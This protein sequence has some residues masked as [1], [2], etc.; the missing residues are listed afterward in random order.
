MASTTTQDAG[1]KYVLPT[2]ASDAARL[3]VIHDVYGPISIR[4][5]EAAAVGEARSAADIGCGTGT[6]SR[7]LAERMGKGSIVDAIDISEDQ[8]AV[9]RNVKSA[10]GASTINYSVASAY[11][12][13]LAEGQ[14]DLVFVRLVLCHLKEPKKAVVAMAKLLKPGGRLVAVDMDRYSTRAMPPSEHYERWL[15]ASHHSKI[16]VD[17]SVGYRLHD[18]MSDAGLRTTFLAADQPIYNTGPGKRLW[19]N[20]W[21]NALP[22]FVR[23]GAVTQEDGE[24]MI[25]G[26]A[27]HN[28]RPDVWIAVAKMFAAVG[29][30]AE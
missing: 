18:L 12:P 28:A 14:Y 2:G 17:F 15:Q 1:D 23:A 13:G 19:E 27:A 29:R 8:L 11:E 24:A 10:P 5:L 3:D 16:G 4:G 20:T 21:R 30:K 25:A 7:L 6:V 26:I 9:A 22:Q